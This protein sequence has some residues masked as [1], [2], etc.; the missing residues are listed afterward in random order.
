MKKYLNLA[1]AAKRAKIAP[2]TFRRWEQQELIKSNSEG[3]FDIVDIDLVAKIKRENKVNTPSS[4]IHGIIQGEKS[5]SSY[6][7][8]VSASP[9]TTE[10][11]ESVTPP[12]AE[13]KAPGGVM[14]IKYEDDA[15]IIKLKRQNK[16]E[17]ISLSFLL[18]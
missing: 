7:T 16:D 1:E 2:R 15:L 18:Q 4:V 14:T 11:D 12:P 9:Q 8:A 10:K 6:K 17:K 5:T 13:P 3:K